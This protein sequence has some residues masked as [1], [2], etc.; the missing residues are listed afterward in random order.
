[1][2]V[3]SSNVVL[4]IAN[5]MKYTNEGEYDL[6]EVTVMPGDTLWGIAKDYSGPE[7]DLRVV[8]DKIMRENDLTDSIVRPGQVLKVAIPL[9]YTP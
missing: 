1:I 6:I 9:A 7:V 3:V 5:A 2:G 4:S 8:V